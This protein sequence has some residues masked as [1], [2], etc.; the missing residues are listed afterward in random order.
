MRLLCK[1]SGGG[2][3]LNVVDALYMSGMKESCGWIVVLLDI[4]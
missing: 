4:P 2:I 3:V 1:G